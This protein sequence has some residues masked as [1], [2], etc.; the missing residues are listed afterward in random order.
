[1]YRRKTLTGSPDP[2]HAT[3]RIKPLHNMAPAML[4]IFSELSAMATDEDIKEAILTNYSDIPRATRLQNIQFNCHL[5]YTLFLSQCRVPE[6][7][8]PGKGGV[9]EMPVQND[10][11]IICIQRHKSPKEQNSPTY[12]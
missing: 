4:H 2:T 5:T 8:S 9:K 12:V 10:S 6:P 1:M 3:R 11:I 7:V